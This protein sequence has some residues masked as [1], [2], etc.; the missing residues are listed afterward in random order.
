MKKFSKSETVFVNNLDIHVQYMNSGNEPIHTHE[1]FEFVYVIEGSVYN[2][3]DGVEYFLI[4]G[5]LVFMGF[6][7]THRIYTDGKV[8]YINILV[9]SNFFQSKG[10]SFGSVFDMLSFI[11]LHDLKAER[12]K[13]LPVICFEGENKKVFDDIVYS[14][15]NEY[16]GKAPY[17][18]K[19]LYHQFHVFLINLIRRLELNEKK[20]A[21]GKVNRNISDIVGYI[22]ENYNKNISLDKVAEKFFY[23][24]T[25]L[26]RMLKAVLGKSFKE[27]L[28]QEKVHHAIEMISSTNLSFEKIATAIGY[29]DKKQFYTMFKKNTGMT[30]GQMR[31]KMLFGHVQSKKSSSKEKTKLIKEE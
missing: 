1:F 19:V 9:D 7:Q 5:S 22:R 27:Y 23:N 18:E 6:D 25:Y 13:T 20:H 11:S 17:Y 31:K 2:E 21:V 24:S 4:P 3:V 29:A 8:A 16:N 14:M 15:L 26:S 10:G 30:P 28:Q 12:E